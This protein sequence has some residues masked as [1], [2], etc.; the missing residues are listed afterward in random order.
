MTAHARRLGEDFFAD[1]IG[2]IRAAAAALA[3]AEAEVVGRFLSSAV[4]P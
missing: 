2:P 1:L 3:P 4:T